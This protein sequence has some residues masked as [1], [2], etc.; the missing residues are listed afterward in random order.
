MLADRQ[1]AVCSKQDRRPD[2]QCSGRHRS[3][4]GVPLAAVPAQNLALRGAN[5]IKLRYSCM[6]TNCSRCGSSMTCG[7]GQGSCW[8]ADLPH[9]VPMPAEPAGCLCPRCL[10]AEIDRLESGQS[11]VES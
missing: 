11:T 6:E 3:R 2:R 9:V 10:Q 4:L 5:R 1:L 8:C 7:K